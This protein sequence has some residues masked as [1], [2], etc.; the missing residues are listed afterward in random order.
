MIYPGGEHSAEWTPPVGWHLD[1]LRSAGFAEA[2][3]LWRGGTDAAVAAVHR[4]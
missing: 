3:L 4:E 1:A 2:G